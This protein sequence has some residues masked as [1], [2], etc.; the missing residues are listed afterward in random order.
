MKILLIDDDPDIRFIAASRLESDG[1]F[2]VTQAAG[3]REALVKLDE[4]IPDAILMDY[5][6]P[7]VDGF[8]LMQALRAR[9]EMRD[10]PVIFFS[11]KADKESIDQFMRIGAAGVIAKPFDSRQLPNEIERILNL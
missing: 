3:G 7:D 2:N 1:G 11:A 6:M 10:I 5:M 8:G 4:G 9:E